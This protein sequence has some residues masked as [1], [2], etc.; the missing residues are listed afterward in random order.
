MSRALLRVL[1]ACWLSTGL[2]CNWVSRPYAIVAP[3]AHALDE[4][5]FMRVE[6]SAIQRVDNCILVPLKLGVALSPADK[7]TLQ[8]HYGVVPLNL[9]GNSSRATKFD[10]DLLLVEP[11]ALRQACDHVSNDARARVSG[12]GAQAVA[13]TG[14]GRFEGQEMESTRRTEST[15]ATKLL[16]SEKTRKDGELDVKISKEQLD[17]GSADLALYLLVQYH[18]APPRSGDLLRLTLA[19]GSTDGG[20]TTIDLRVVRKANPVLAVLAGITA[21]VGGT[22]AIVLATD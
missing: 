4:A 22:L 9:A 12:D 18:R 6:T 2:G 7:Q 20:S 1:L 11:D 14:A 17:T 5:F 19:S 16:S 3:R 21:V 8:L 10:Y 13:S 15:E